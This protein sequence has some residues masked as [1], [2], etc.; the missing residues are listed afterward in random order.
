LPPINY[1][2]DARLAARRD[3][4]RPFEYVSTRLEA[5]VGTV[6]RI[7]V[8]TKDSELDF[9]STGLPPDL[10]ERFEYELEVFRREADEA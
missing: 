5:L 7:V 4:K 9:G 1:Q 10:P 8:I 2:C 6:F 3:A